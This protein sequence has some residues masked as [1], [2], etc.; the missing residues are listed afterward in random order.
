MLEKLAFVV[1][2]VS[3]ITVGFISN[4]AVGSLRDK[5]DLDASLKTGSKVINANETD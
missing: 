1:I 5:P 4:T 3:A 2:L